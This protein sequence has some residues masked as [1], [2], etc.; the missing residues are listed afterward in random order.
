MSTDTIFSLGADQ[1]LSQWELSFP[2]GIPTGGGAENVALRVDTSFTIPEQSVGTYTINKKGI[3][4]PKTNTQTQNTKTFTIEWRIDQDWITFE[5]MKKWATAVYDHINGTA[6][7]EIS[8]RATVLL[9]LLDTQNTVKKLI[10]FK[11]CKPSGYSLS[12]LDNASGEPMRCTMTFI[13]VD[14]IV[15]NA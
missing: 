7:P 1:L 10:R 9:S 11:N 3:T 15:E 8:V 2:D 5:D 12:A 14:F 4:V 6:L 13:Y